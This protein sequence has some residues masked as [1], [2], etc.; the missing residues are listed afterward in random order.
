MN[1]YNETLRGLI[2]FG[3]GE[4][5]WQSWVDRYEEKYDELVIDGFEM[6]P[7]SLS[8]EWKQIVAATGMT[9]LP[10]YVDPESEGY[11]VALRQLA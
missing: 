7:P 3:L 2:D 4:D 1:T 8:Y 11:E 9:P 10:T 5:D 6:A